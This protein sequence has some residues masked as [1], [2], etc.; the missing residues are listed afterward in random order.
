MFHVIAID[1]FLKFKILG[2]FQAKFIAVHV[3]V[4]LRLK[5]IGSDLGF[6]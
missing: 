3:R 1:H 5:I 6:E 4:N 2:E